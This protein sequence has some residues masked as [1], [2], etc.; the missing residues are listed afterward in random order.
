MS[1]RRL[2]RSKRSQILKI[3]ARHGARTVRVCGSVVRGTARRNRDI[4]FLVDMEEGRSPLDHAALDLD[5]ERLPNRPVNVASERGLR[6]VL[7]KH[8]LKDA[9]VL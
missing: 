1:V 2:L 5:L 4:D 3:A 8:V 6:R 7:R 9:V